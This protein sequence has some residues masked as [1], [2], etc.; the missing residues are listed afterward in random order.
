MSQAKFINKVNISTLLHDV[1]NAVVSESVILKQMMDGEYGST[2][3]EIKTI[4]I[5]LWQTNN[6]VIQLI[7]RYQN[8]Q[9][10]DRVIGLN[11]SLINEFDF[12]DLLNNLYQEYMPKAINR[13]LKLHYKTCKKYVHG[14]R[15]KGDATHLYRMCSNLLQNALSYTETGDILLRL[16]NQ[17][18]DLVV[19]IED[20]G[21]G[22]GSEDLANIFLPFYRG[23]ISS[24]G[25]GLGL[26]IAMMVA[27]SHGLKLS[28]D[29]VVGK[30]TI[31][32]IKFPYQ[33]NNF[34][35]VDATIPK[36]PKLTHAL[37]GRH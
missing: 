13:G 19:L 7:E 1:S 20:T 6:Q 9:S 31:F 26:Y 16:L 4:L 10:R 11:P 12:G 29:S 27:Y 3:Q 36:K 34:Y 30:G 14:T 17:G 28:V 33:V 24:P 37:P 5:S 8:H 32:T 35:G 15:V 18:D 2:L 25:S 22:I 21:I 23:T